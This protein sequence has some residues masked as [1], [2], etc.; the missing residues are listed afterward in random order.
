[1]SKFDGAKDKF[2]LGKAFLKPKG[3]QSKVDIRDSKAE[4]KVE[5]FKSLRRVVGSSN[6]HPC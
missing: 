3:L 5:R 1:M 2:G 6:V 4:A